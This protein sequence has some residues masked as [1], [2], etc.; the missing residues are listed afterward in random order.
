MP[1][2][3][4]IESLH[5]FFLLEE[6][7][8]VPDMG[9]EKLFGMCKYAKNVELFYS[10]MLDTQYISINSDDI[11][12]IIKFVKTQEGIKYSQDLYDNPDFYGWQK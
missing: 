10:E 11:D 2:A 1:R 7:N 3:I 5:S 12:K 4:L 6:N 8:C 9:D